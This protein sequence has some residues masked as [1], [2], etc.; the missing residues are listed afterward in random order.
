MESYL[1]ADSAADFAADS[2]A[3]SDGDNY[4]CPDFSRCLDCFSDILAPCEIS[5][6]NLT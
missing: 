4:D 5:A 3:D 2:A 6:V 1:A